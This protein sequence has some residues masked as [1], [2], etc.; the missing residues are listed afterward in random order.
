MKKVMKF[1]Q[2]LVPLVLSGEK[3]T[4]WRLW[5]DKNLQEGDYIS[6]VKRPELEEFAQAIITNV[7]EKKMG[8]INKDDFLGHE[9]FKNQK[10]MY[11]T[12]SD[13]YKRKVDGNTPVKIIRFRLIK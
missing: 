13:Y 9:K 6:L 7:S 12:Y 3:A 1:S 10:E 4:T 2:E 11:E 8:R 5:D